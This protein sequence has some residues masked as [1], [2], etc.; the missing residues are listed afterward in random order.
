MLAVA[1]FGIVMLTMSIRSTTSNGSGTVPAPSMPGSTTV[2]ESTRATVA[3][4]AVIVT[5][6]SGKSSAAVPV[7]GTPKGPPLHDF[8]TV[9][10]SGRSRIWI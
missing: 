7:G 3:F 8:A 1:P 6:D 4:V 9:T 2:S 5:R 10:F